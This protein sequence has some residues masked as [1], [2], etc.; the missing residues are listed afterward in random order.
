MSWGVEV[1]ALSE[2]LD[3]IREWNIILLGMV[4][5]F[6]NRLIKIQDKHSDLLAKQD[7]RLAVAE[8]RLDYVEEALTK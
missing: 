7:K 8:K 4:A 5:Y 2:L 1:R 3:I 6:T